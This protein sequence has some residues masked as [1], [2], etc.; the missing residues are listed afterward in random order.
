VGS[1]HRP[2]PIF[3]V[4]KNS[5]RSSG[6]G[7]IELPPDIGH[8]PEQLHGLVRQRQETL[9]LIERRALSSFASTITAK[10]AI[11]RRAAR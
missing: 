3:R 11:S 8:R 4:R 10:E 5:A 7:L 6:L 1:R 9:P 2:N